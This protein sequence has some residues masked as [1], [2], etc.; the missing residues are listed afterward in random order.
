MGSFR[1]FR[2]ES[3]GCASAIERPRVRNKDRNNAGS[4]LEGSPRLA[5]RTP[6]SLLSCKTRTRPARGKDCQTSGRG[7]CTSSQ[8]L[9]FLMPASLLQLSYWAGARLVYGAVRHSQ[10]RTGR[11]DRA[12]ARP[13]LGG[14]AWPGG[15]S[16]SII[17]LLPIGSYLGDLDDSCA[18]SDPAAQEIM[19][20]R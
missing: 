5:L 4:L 14:P 19:M 18:L 10:W 7:R 11:H 3:D 16:S 1:I 15:V 12:E 20:G 9:V 8:A 6:K 17:H 13:R 2:T